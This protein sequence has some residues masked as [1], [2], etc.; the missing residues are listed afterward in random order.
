MPTRAVVIIMPLS[1]TSPEPIRAVLT[2]PT[3]SE[4]FYSLIRSMIQE[5]PFLSIPPVYL[6]D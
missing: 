4:S 3:E 6:N 5:T 2:D 1:D